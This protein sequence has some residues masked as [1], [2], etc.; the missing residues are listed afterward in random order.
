MNLLARLKSQTVGDHDN[1]WERPGPT[2]DELRRDVIGVVIFAL[3]SA[4]ALELTRGF[5]MVEEDNHP[6]WVQHGVLAL[7]IVPLVLR[8]K[9]PVLVMLAMSALFIGLSLLSP[10]V[11]LQLSYQVAYFASL[12]SAIAWA[13][14]RRMLW[15][16]IAVVVAA[17]ALWLILALTVA[18]TFDGVLAQ[19]EDNPDFVG[20]ILDPLA[21]VAL[22]NFLVNFA[23]F[24]GAIL[25]G[26]TSW[27]NA[28]QRTQLA[29]QAAEITRQADELA[30]R[31]VVE[32]R[33]RIARELHDVVAH[34]VSVIG[35]QAGAARRVIEKRPEVAVESL[36]TIEQASR[37]AVTDMRNLLGVLRSES[38]DL[39]DTDDGGRRPEPGL[40]DL[41][42]LARQHRELGLT[43][44]FG[45]VEDIPGALARVSA[46]LALSL[47]RT[48]Q[49]SLTNV[50]RH[51]TAGSA[52][53]TLRTGLVGDQRWV[54][55]E[56]VDNGM[57]RPKSE[58][59]SG[60]G[61]QGIR[62]RVALHRGTAEIGPRSEGGWRVRARFLVH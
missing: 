47:F 30:R 41:E 4:F 42:A 27:R 8:R 11:S 14:D 13:K 29:E 17:M 2:K 19:S 51:S 38:T 52:V 34:H 36:R 12:Y 50:R 32:E 21:S 28:L 35:V 20:G 9:Y 58:P 62:E 55:L 1:N 24:G 57:P 61:L 39:G 54:E 7:M 37:Q 43:V 60:F 53:M 56:T 45:M 46:P 49:E 26:M 6:V 23:Y 15:L 22:Y 16:G 44:K 10:L 48:A 5:G 18:N 59:G 40:D 31:A 33:L 25:A 3:V